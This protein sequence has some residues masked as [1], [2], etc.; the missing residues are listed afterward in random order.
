MILKS[1]KVSL[2][3]SSQAFAGVVISWVIIYQYL[4]LQGLDPASQ[5]YREVPLVVS[6]PV[7]KYPGSSSKH[8]MSLT[9]VAQ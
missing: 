1:T 2:W 3:K 6:K 7:R 4:S 8:M 9:G 5:Y